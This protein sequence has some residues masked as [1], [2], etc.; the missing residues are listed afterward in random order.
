[1]PESVHGSI[2][3]FGKD[4]RL[5]GYLSLPTSASKSSPAVIIIHEWWGLAPHIKDVADRYAAEG[6]VALAPDLYGGEVATT[7]DLAMKL[8]SSVTTQASAEIIG[9][10]LDYLKNSNLAAPDKV[11]ITGFCFGGTHSFNFACVAGK[12]IA[13]AAPYYATRLPSE[14]LLTKIAAP[15]LIIYGEEDRSIRPDQARK[16]EANLKQLGKNVQL[17]LYPGCPHAFFNDQSP[18]SYRPEAAK[19]A[20]QKTLAFFKANLR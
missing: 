3:S 8:S 4:G 2:V 6:Y 1:M 10:S 12:R 9:E 5:S 19:D 13:A 11:G 7:P 16:L 17:L 15:L 18:Q 20:W 14:D